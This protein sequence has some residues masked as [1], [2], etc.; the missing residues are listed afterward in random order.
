MDIS[1]TKPELRRFI[2]EQVRGGSFSS[3]ADVVEAGLER[4]ML[5]LTP[6]ELDEET[7]RSIERAEAEFD[8][9]EDRSFAEVAA[10]FRKKYLGK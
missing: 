5:D 3:P 7:I 6:D 1:L 8:R 2:E 9:G 10:E 4:L